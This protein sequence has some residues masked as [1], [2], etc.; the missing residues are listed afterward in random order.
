MALTDL[1]RISTS[2]IATGSTIDSPILR[3]D[4]SLR[5]SQVGVTSALF[6]SSDDALEFNDNVKLKFGNSGDLEIYHQNNVSYIDDTTGNQL[7]IQANDLRIRKQDSGEEMITAF[8]NGT[9]NLF[10]NGDQK[11][12]T[13][14]TG[15][16]VTGIL[17]ATTFSGP[18]GNTSGISTFYDLRV[19]NNLTVEG[20][21][22]TIDTN[23]IGVDRVEVGANSNTV[24]GIAVTQSG[25]AD[26][27]RLY[28]GSTQVVTVDDVGNVG[29]ASATPTQKLD[30]NGIIAASQG[31]RV[32]N[33]S[34][35]TNYISVGNGGALRLWGTS[36]QFADIR[37]GNLHF[38]NGSLENILEIQQDKD[39]WM[40]GPMYA[41]DTARFTQ[42]VSIAD[43]IEH[44]GDTDTA[45]RF[46]AADTIR[47]EVGN[48]QAVHILPA[49]AGSGGARMG[50]GTNNP[51]G[52]LHIYG[53]NPPFRIQNSN[54]SANLQMGMWDAANIMLQAS[55][56]TFKFATETSNHIT[57]F[58]GGLANVNERCRIT[59][60]G[61]FGVG[62]TDPV[63]KFHVKDSG[64]SHGGLNAHVS[65]EDT[66]SLAANVGGLQVFE[67]IYDSS[68]NSA[69]YAAIHGGKDNAT[70][71]NYAG[72]LR[73]F[74]RPNGALPVERVRITS[75]GTVKISSPGVNDLRTLAVLAP[76]S[77][78][79]FG[80]TVNVGGFLMSSNN[81]Q[82][83]LSG[84]GYFNGSNWVATHTASAQIRTDGDG[85][86]SFCANT[87]LTSGNTFTPSEKVTFHVSGYVGIN[88][89]SNNA[90]LIIKGNSDVGDND[91][92]LRIY[93]MDTTVGSQIPSISFWGGS[94]QLAYMRGTSSGLRFYTGSSG[95]MAF[96]GAFDNNQRLLLG[97]DSNIQVD[98]SNPR[99]QVIGT[100]DSTA[101]LSIGNFSASVTPATLSL[102]KSRGGV[103]AYTAVQDDDVL[104]KINFIGADGTDLAEVSGKILV[105]CDAAVANNRV[106]S[107]MEFYNTDG[108]GTLD[109]NMVLTRDS[110]LFLTS[111]ITRD[112]MHSLAHNTANDFVFGRTTGN[113]D[114]GMTIVTPS[115]TS[116]FINF[117]DADGQRQ[118]A[119]VYKHGSG[120]DKMYFRTNNN[121]TAMVLDSSQN[122]GIGIDPP[123]TKLNVIGTISTGRNVARE[124]G[125]II[126]VSSNHPG[127]PGSNVI[128]GYKNYED[129][130][131]W[132]AAGGSRTNANLTI[133]LGSAK[134]CD[135][136]VIYNQNEY[137][138]SHREVKRFTLEGSNDNSN[139][140]T[141][142]DDNAGCSNGHEPNPG[143]SFR[144]P[145]DRD[146][147]EEG[148]SYR[149]WRFTMKDF[150]GSDSYGGI[151]E[152]ELYEVGG[153]PAGGD[154]DSVGSEIS[155]HSL[156]ATDVSAEIV[157]TTGQ[158]AF[159]VSRENTFPS[160]GDYSANTTIIFDNDS[161]DG[162]F[163]TG[164]TPHCDYY[165]KTN[166][167]FT[168]PVSGIYFFS[169]T[170][171][172]QNSTG[173]YDM[174][175]KTTP[176][177]FYL[178]P[179]RKA[180][181]PGSTSWSTSGTVYLAF[182][183]DCM[184]YL[185]KGQT[186]EVRFTTFGGGQIYGGGSWTR[187]CGY[188]LG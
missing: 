111:G 56:R 97:N 17:T 77:Q 173:N 183:G 107:R 168:A 2:G 158:P 49:S 169:T 180:S 152:L 98:S 4:V 126:N 146:D 159:S 22:T 20:S 155:T 69:I 165:N 64:V 83:G 137:Q 95:S 59:S 105:A 37:V 62:D 96:S 113:A 55:N 46:P 172:V 177:D 68:G 8:A 75:A 73:F 171:L 108:N 136:F 185:K 181:N 130:M 18:I 33:G 21:T 160:S 61:K 135:R 34:A 164:T 90:R 153:I 66:T 116:G 29:I 122:I 32:P 141:I 85:D 120:S 54:D 88:D 182:G 39:I 124:F 81:G 109:L 40:Y 110:Q 112:A 63:V 10:H 78:I 52:M 58:T 15:A 123:Q 102:V 187:F 41:E 166:G 7:R 118:G 76:K 184:V 26:I 91:C 89:T 19:S 9:V 134:T 5:G 149:Y 128:N 139:W 140:T 82:F 31:L 145:A 127:R 186:A 84:G 50:L 43:K 14:S 162:W 72:Y 121:Q 42:T 144:I 138:N 176:R 174:I 151:C 170:V 106:P 175:I 143:W 1:T 35:S 115:A 117:A 103:G 47:F 133:D 148:K 38:R 44:F 80:T 142:L 86:I 60:N 150:H 27:V 92:Q 25:T 24:T 71:G 48:Q 13:A 30:V 147:D 167:L 28:D 93:D 161:G 99:L 100:S 65:I 163:Q 188:L 94:T 101:H 16:V 45:I 125:T 57:F 36:H 114:T 87:G 154:A 132:L 70:S 157:R 79:Q 119:I 6:D 67:G 53:S 51:T 23:L 179:G 12:R 156:V 178:A 129:Q 104:G 3:K 131:D 11:F 74:T